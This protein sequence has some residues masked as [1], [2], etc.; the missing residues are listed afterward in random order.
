MLCTS[1]IHFLIQYCTIVESFFVM[2][3]VSGLLYLRWKNP[4]LARP[5]RVNIFVPIFFVLICIFLIVLH[6]FDSPL[7]LLGGA[8]ITLS[9]I[10]VYYFGVVWSEKPKWFIHFMEH[11]TFFS[12]KVF[13]SPHEDDDAEDF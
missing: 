3:F 5:I 11:L 9:D 8:L 4:K 2:F 7:T 6:I 1:D 12:Q 10:P 13:F